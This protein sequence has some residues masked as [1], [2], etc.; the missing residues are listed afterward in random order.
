MLYQIGAHAVALLHLGFIIFVIAGGFVV[1]KWPRFAWIHLPAA[2]WGALIEF[3][4]WP[5]PLTRL[6]NDLLRRAGRAGYETGF[7]EH[8][9]FPILYPGGLT[10]GIEVAIGLFVLVLNAAVYARAF[11]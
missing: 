11:R 2:I 5:C 9:I 10:R 4:S 1:L 3:A 7:I 8:Y 6:E